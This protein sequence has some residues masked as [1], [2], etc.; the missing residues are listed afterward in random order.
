MDYR[1]RLIDEEGVYLPLH[2]LDVVTNDTDES[3][4]TCSLMT[5][6]YLLANNH[7]LSLYGYIQ[8]PTGKSDISFDGPITIDL[9]IITLA[10]M[11]CPAAWHLLEYL[12]EIG[13]DTDPISSVN[14]VYMDQPP[15]TYNN[16]MTKSYPPYYTTI[17][18]LSPPSNPYTN[19]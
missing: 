5:I 15:I 3:L 1:F 14:K 11:Q 2:N 17:D 4:G 9:W 19:N 12:S 8:S 7:A 10:N 6:T 16:G 13:I 18:E